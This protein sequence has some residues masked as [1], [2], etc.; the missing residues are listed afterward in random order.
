M[1]SDD[2]DMIVVGRFDGGGIIADVEIPEGLAIYYGPE[3]GHHRR[4]LA[5]KDDYERL[6]RISQIATAPPN[7]PP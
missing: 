1:T 5:R 4:A 6:A 7:L 3:D 2:D